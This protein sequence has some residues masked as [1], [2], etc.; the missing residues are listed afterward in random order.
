MILHIYACL[1]YRHSSKNKFMFPFCYFLI[2]DEQ[3]SFGVFFEILLAFA[4]VVWLWDHTAQ[5][6][7]NKRKTAIMIETL[8]PALSLSLY[9][10]FFGWSISNK[11]RLNRCFNAPRSHLQSW[12]SPCRLG[13][14][15]HPKIGKLNEQFGSSNGYLVWTNSLR[16]SRWVVAN[17]GFVYIY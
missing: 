13:R 8:L 1:Y 11:W 4:Y 7:S 12:I 17:S 10:L 2:L 6:N 9:L 14:G 16:P 15:Y 5:C 3:H